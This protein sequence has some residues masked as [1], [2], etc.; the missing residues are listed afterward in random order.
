[1]KEAAMLL[2]FF[3]LLL[4]S[5]NSQNSVLKCPTHEELSFL[6]EF[7]IKK[8]GKILKED[9]SDKKV[10]HIFRV[11]LPHL[12]DS[13]QMSDSLILS[14]TH[15]KYSQK[16]IS[17]GR[18]R[19]LPEVESFVVDSCGNVLYYYNM[20]RKRRNVSR[21]KYEVGYYLS[22]SI[23]HL[24]AFNA[25]YAFIPSVGYM[26]SIG[27]LLVYDN[28]TYKLYEKSHDGLKKVDIRK[29]ILRFPR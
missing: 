11:K 21:N 17:S 1:M 6:N 22:G 24:L 25:A 7:V 2:I 18:K 15:V 9:L 4:R 29:F 3:L 28:K 10:F 19:L 13:V 16:K 27:D 5:G 12:A 8:A 23:K 20:I 26:V 14:M